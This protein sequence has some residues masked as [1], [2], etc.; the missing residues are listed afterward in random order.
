MIDIYTKVWNRPLLIES[1]EYG[2]NEIKNNPRL[3]LPEAPA[4]MGK[5]TMKE[6][7]AR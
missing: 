7:A 2:E 4:E 1:N 6:T 5:N 3:R